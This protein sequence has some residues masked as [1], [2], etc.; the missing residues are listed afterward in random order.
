MGASTGNAVYYDPYNVDIVRD[1]YPVYRRLRE[2]APLYYNPEHDFYAVSRFDD[3]QQGLANH[4]TFIS[5]RGGILELIKANVEMPPGTFIFEDPPLHTVHRGVVA[6]I[7]SPRRMNGLDAMIREFTART[8]DS[9]V[10]RDSFDFIADIGAQV[11][12]RVIGML[13]GIPEEDQ[14]GVRERADAR[15]RTE[16]G[17]PLSYDEGF[18]LA[19]GFEE[20]IDWRVKNPSDDVMTELLTIEFTDETGTNRRLTRDEV[21]T[22]V[23]VIAGAGNE[24]TN[25]LIG[26]TAK[27]LAEHPD[28]RRE[29]VADPSLI[30]EA[31]EEVLRYEPMGTHVGRYVARDVEYY[32]QTVPQG[33][34]ILFLVGSANRDEQR[35]PDP[36]RFDI[37]RNR[38]AHVTFGSGIHTCP[39]NVLARLEGRIVL[40][41]VLKRF[42]EWEI[43]ME[44]AELSSTST[45]RGWETLPAYIGSVPVRAAARQPVPAAETVTAPMASVEGKWAVTIKGP[46]GPQA[47]TLVL[48]SVDGVLTGTQSG[49]GATTP[50]DAATFENGKIFWSQQITKPMKLKLEFSG[51]VDG[52]SMEGKVK[53]G[54]MGSFGFTAVKC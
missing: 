39:G 48:E 21:L 35:F 45:V 33:S 32:G 11:P 37:H 12:M 20:Y 36:D 49:E 40:E 53:T 9:L 42:P 29:L 38:A 25:R 43:D 47:T 23:N 6:R 44:N 28:Q 3:V 10:G 17:Q 31:I 8:L 30:P 16:A 52:D 14:Q 2:E 50:I 51:T 22:F 18:S 41:E 26:W 7:F 19:G 46:T 4:E 24:T 1:P 13:L 54:F 27:T 5:S 34:A 15:L